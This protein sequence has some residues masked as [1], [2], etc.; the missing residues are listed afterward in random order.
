VGGGRPLAPTTQPSSSSPA[1]SPPPGLTRV[2]PLL[3]LDLPALQV[4]VTPIDRL[5]PSIVKSTVQ[6]PLAFPAETGLGLA[7]RKKP[8]KG[9]PAQPKKYNAPKPFRCEAHQASKGE[10]RRTRCQSQ[11]LAAGAT[12]VTADASASLAAPASHH[13]DPLLLHL[14][15][16]LLSVYR[17]FLQ[18]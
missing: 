16:V 8:R 3:W 13:G 11:T 2:S 1:T 9:G 12:T 5:A 15:V 17:G 14:A 10:G 18:E 4:M 6:I 7:D